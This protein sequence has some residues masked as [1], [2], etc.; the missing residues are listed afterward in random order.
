MNAYSHSLL[1]L[2]PPSM[3]PSSSSSL[4]HFVV[5]CPSSSPSISS[6]PSSSP[7]TSMSPSTSPVSLFN[8]FIEAAPARDPL[9]E[10]NLENI[11]VLSSPYE[12][13]FSFKSIKE[14][15]RLGSSVAM[16]GGEDQGGETFAIGIRTAQNRKGES[17]GAAFLFDRN[18]DDPRFPPM[19]ITGTGPG[20]GFGSAVAISRYGKRVTIGA[21]YEDG[22]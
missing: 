21:P 15:D 6:M 3:P 10:A 4:D 19:F 22:A 20:D 17:T 2:P 8:V 1:F 11:D 12:F 14:N 18:E 7:T 16:S 9:L 5:P 13:T